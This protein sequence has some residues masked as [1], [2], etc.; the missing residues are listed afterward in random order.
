VLDVSPVIVDALEQRDA[1]VTARDCLAIEDAAAKAQ[2]HSTHQ[3]ESGF[4]PRSLTVLR[5]RATIISAW[6]TQ[7]VS[8]RCLRCSP[9]SFAVWR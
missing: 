8:W 2:G 6:T 9:R 3:G 5:H 4:H 7:Y 1:I